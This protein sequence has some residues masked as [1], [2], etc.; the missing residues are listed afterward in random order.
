VKRG[1]ANSARLFLGL[2]LLLLLSIQPLFAHGDLHER[3]Q[4]LNARLAI[5]TNDA[6]LLVQ[7]AELHREHHDWLAAAVDLDQAQLIDP[8]LKRIDF[9]RARLARDMGDAANAQ[10]YLDRLLTSVTNDVEAMTLRARVRAE[11]GDAA[12][13]VADYSLAIAWSREPQPEWV[14]E[15][16]DLLA[17]Q[18][19]GAAAL[20]GLDEGVARLGNLIVL[21]SRALDLEL[22]RTNYSGALERLEAILRSA[23]RREA[24]LARQGDVLRL[25]GREAEARSAWREANKAIDVLPERWRTTEAMLALRQRINGELARSADDPIKPAPAR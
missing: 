25:V 20:R 13:A 17:A 11:R 7:R 16:A 21:Q 15:R 3:I 4:V 6:A 5:A 22:A 10:A 12:G 2:G 24:W 19:Q 1:F 14:L 18:G 8:G 9:F 23:P